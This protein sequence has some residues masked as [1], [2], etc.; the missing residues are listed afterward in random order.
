[1]PDMGADLSSQMT[2]ELAA[3][4]AAGLRRVVREVGSPQQSRI[5]LDGR[6]V[7]NFSSNDYLSLA[8][9]SA[10]KA[11]AISAIEAQGAGCGA[12]RLISGSQAVHQRLETALA[13]F[14][15]TEAALAFSSGYAAALGTVPALVGKGDLV[16]IDK[17]V[18]AS[19]VDAA[20]L[21]GARLRV[22]RHNDMVSL[23]KIL[24]QSAGKY[25]RT[26][27]IAESVYSMDG[28]LAP[29]INLVD[30]KTAHGAA[31]GFRSPNKGSRLWRR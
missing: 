7:L 6:E 9:H 16:V 30:L 12:A 27:V 22:F 11:A 5:T 18:H 17:L 26:L 2:E 24:K 3:L 31:P 8:N 28:D 13:A 21:S 14:K 19:L 23:G 15:N 20:K 10:L 25:R 4:D 1:M 29:L